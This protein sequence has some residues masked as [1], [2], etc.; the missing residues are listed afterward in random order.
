MTQTSNE[1]SGKQGV[2][3]DVSDMVIS[4]LDNA[5]GGVIGHV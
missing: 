3:Q 1:S 5:T 4:V 2:Y